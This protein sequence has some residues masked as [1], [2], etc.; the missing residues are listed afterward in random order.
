MSGTL[1][2]V[3]SGELRFAR[4][5]PGAGER[6]AWG[7]PGHPAAASIWQDAKTVLVTRVTG[8]Q[9]LVTVPRLVIPI[10]HNQLAFRVSSHSS[11][12]DQLVADGRV[13]VQPGDWRGSPTLGSQQRQG[14]A[15]VVT[16]GT[17]LPFVQSEIDAKY[18][19]RM[20]L[21]RFAHRV[22]RGAAPY[23]D[24]VVLVTVYEPVP[25]LLP[26]R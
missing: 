23:G 14:R 6:P 4:P 11:E 10:G 2:D 3:P 13:L 16:G 8:P 18:K 7:G 19:W 25:M 22:A 20:P 26:P 9:Q 1:V 15:Q 24:V 17:L 12:P 21:A 5:E